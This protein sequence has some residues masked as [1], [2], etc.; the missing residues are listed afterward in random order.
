MIKAIVFDYDGTLSNRL[1]SAYKTYQVIVSM[2]FPDLD[3]NSMEFEGIVQRIMTWDEYGSIS[4]DHV[5]GMLNK[6]YKLDLDPK[7]WLN[8]WYDN[9]YLNQVLQDDCLEVLAK[10]KEKYKIG[11]LTNG[12]E[13]TQKIKLEYTHVIDY[14]DAYLI[15][16]AVGLHKPDVRLFEMIAEKLGVA[17]DEIAFVGDTF[18]TDILG[19]YRANRLPIWFFTDTH[20]V[21]DHDIKR[22]FS[23]KELLEIF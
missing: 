5:F 18:Y 9:F 7:K 10:L 16:G 17:C 14:F 23:L 15:S 8:V 6:Y 22:I 3:V 2:I 13:D 19:A 20:R 21:S 4:K 11:C 12:P 1:Y